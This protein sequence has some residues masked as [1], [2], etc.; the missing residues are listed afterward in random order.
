M[1][2][3]ICFVLAFLELF[4]QAELLDRRR[5]RKLR[6]KELKAKE[7]RDEETKN[8]DGFHL[9]EAEPPSEILAHVNAFDLERNDLDV[10]SEISLFKMSQRPIVEEADP[11]VQTSVAFVDKDS[12]ACENVE[13]RNHPP[14]GVPCWPMPPKRRA[15]SNGFYQM[16][17][18]STSKPEFKFSKHGMRDLRVSHTVKN[19]KVWSRKPQPE[20]DEENLKFRMREAS[21]LVAQNNMEQQLLIGSI[22]VNLGSSDIREKCDCADLPVDDCELENQPLK[23]VTNVKERNSKIQGGVNQ[24]TVK[25]WRRRQEVKDSIPVQREAE[26]DTSALKEDSWTV[27][28]ERCV[29]SSSLNAGS[30]LFSS[31]AARTFLSRSKLAMLVRL[32]VTS[33]KDRSYC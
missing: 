10:P 33:F 18:L 30:L 8:R 23:Q 2:K 14:F 25:L 15:M 27:N 28:N 19:K 5:R 1:G 31:E 11:K 13:L 12:N 4:R 22:A 32:Y 7:H 16:K 24:S 20:K 17:S 29:G 26:V 9:M 3:L 6:Q 21:V